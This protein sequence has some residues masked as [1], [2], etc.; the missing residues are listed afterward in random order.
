MTVPPAEHREPTLVSVVVPT[1]DV[2]MLRRQLA[3]LTAQDFSGA[4]EVV[5]ADNTAGG[6]AAN[7]VH[8]L[9]AR[10]PRARVVRVDGARGACHARNVGAAA[11]HG[12]LLAFCDDDDEVEPGWVTAIADAASRAD[13]VGGPV[14]YTK[15]NH[16]R[17]ASGPCGRRE[18]ALRTDLGFLPWVVAANCG[19]WRSV[20]EAVGG[21][22]ETYD[23]CTDIELSWRVQ[24]AAYELR[25]APDA[26]VNYRFRPTVWQAMRQAFDWG[27]AHARLYRDFRGA[28]LPRTRLR[29]AARLWARLAVGVPDLV[30]DPARRGEWLRHLAERLGRVAGSIRYRV[31]FL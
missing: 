30:R 1:R 17:V 5:I 22:N 14:G 29:R 25:P 7:E 20:L 19:I 4:W 13:M 11:A 3:A 6:A 28:G 10:L 24:L 16:D 9:T 27:V 26:L 2:R 21:W 8:P 31:L 15:L 12:D 18:T 23:R